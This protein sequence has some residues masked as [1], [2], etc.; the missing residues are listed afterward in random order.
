MSKLNRLLIIGVCTVILIV[1]C[2]RSPNSSNKDSTTSTISRSCRVVSHEMGETEVCGQP[3]KVAALTPHIL[4]SMLALGVQPAAYAETENLKIKTYDNPASQIPYIGKWVTTKPIGL[5]SRDAPSLERLALLQPD[6]ILGEKWSG[7]DKYPLLTQIAPTLLFSDEGADGQQNWQHDI[8]GIAKALGKQT[9]A[10]ELLTAF[11][12]KIAQTRV[13]LQPVLQTYPRVFLI[14]SDLSTYV[15]LEADSTTSRL[16]K[17]IG[18]KIVKPSGTQDD[19]EI[20]FEIVP[21]VETDII[22][23][24]SSLDRQLDFFNSLDALQD[25]LQKRWANN[26]LLSSMSVFQQGRV[27][28]VGYQLWGSRIRGPLA[29]SLILEALPDLLLHSVEEK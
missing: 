5:G 17:E 7:E 6:L 3:Q 25:T 10:E 9:Q 16:L 23:V 18:F 15:G 19:A 8:K 27:Y 11:D 12:Q 2:T 22:I 29:D 26:P 20:S 1:A 13:A 14:N 4:D 21:K 24:L 28:F